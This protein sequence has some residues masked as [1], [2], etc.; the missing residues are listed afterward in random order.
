MELLAKVP[1]FSGFSSADLQALLATAVER[2]MR[3]GQMLFQ[4]GDAGS[5]MMA[6]LEGEVRVELR[7]LAG[8]N[9]VVRVLRKGEVFGEL[10]LFDGKPRSADVVAATNGRLLIIERRAVLG[11]IEA[12][13]GFAIRVLGVLCDRLRTTT[14]QL[15]AMRFQDAG[16]RIC[17]VLLQLAAE[18][19]QPRLNITQ[20][21]LAEIVGAARETVNRRLAEL[22]DAGALARAPG[23][24]T[25]LNAEI[26][27][28][29]LA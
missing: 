7:G 15:E 17:K 1:L 29:R 9:H 26:L 24:I 5:S 4:R 14:A 28:A 6:V 10:A 8:A 27:E 12:D 11:L 2:R 3:N 13:P 16:Q 18:T 25:L 22:E 20:T 21:A 23:R 19:G